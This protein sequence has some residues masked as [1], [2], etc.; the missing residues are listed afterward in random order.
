MA[1]FFR[2]P[3]TTSS[4]TIV[5]VELREAGFPGFRGQQSPP[6]QGTVPELLCRRS[7]R[8]LE[9]S[10]DFLHPL[11]KLNTTFFFQPC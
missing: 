3:Q 10:I 11:L 1:G 9:A 6:S 8:L 5:P 7:I 2:G 4:G